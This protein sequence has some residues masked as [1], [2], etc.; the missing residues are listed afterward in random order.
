MWLYLLCI[1][2]LRVCSFT[3][4]FDGKHSIEVL[5]LVKCMEYYL[6]YA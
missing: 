2:A 3:G 4:G 6:W 5:A 1:V